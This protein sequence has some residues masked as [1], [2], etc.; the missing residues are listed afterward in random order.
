[1]QQKEISKKSLFLVAFKA[2]YKVSDSYLIN[3]ATEKLKE[4]D[5]DLIVANDIGRRGSNIG[6]DNNEVI[7]V[8]REKEVIHLPLQ[9]KR[10]VA[11]SIL[12][13]VVQSLP[14]NKK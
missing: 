6:S 11:N 12:Q 5:G 3:K 1:M 7:V 13:L 10:K 2:E 9:D 8:S 4:C 14:T